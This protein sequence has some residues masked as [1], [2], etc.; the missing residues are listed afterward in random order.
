MLKIAFGRA[1]LLLIVSLLWHQT[2]GVRAAESN[3]RPHLFSLNEDMIRGLDRDNKVDVKDPRSVLYALLSQLQPEATI[4]PSENYYYFTF[5]DHGLAYSGSLRL[6]ADSRDKGLI[7]LNYNEAYSR[8]QRSEGGVETTLG[9]DDGVRVEKLARFLYRVTYRDV[10]VSFKLHELDM[11][12]SSGTKLFPGEVYVGSLFDESG[13]EFDL[14]YSAPRNAFMF[15]LRT[16]GSGNEYLRDIGGGLLLGRR[17]GFVYYNDTMFNRLILVAVN[18]DMLREN[19]AY[20]G[21]FD[22]LPENYFDELKFLDYVYKVYP[23]L[24]GELQPH[25]TYADG[26]IF[27]LIAYVE[28]HTLSDLDFLRRCNAKSP[29]RDRFYDC[30]LPRR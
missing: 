6:P 1:V 7:E 2:Y 26:T 20:D 23:H 4:F 19:S 25:G 18:S 15:L 8:W 16:A 27:A 13:I 3:P 30:I 28:Y 14:V 29:R 11:T 10:S 24:K 12:L 9:P 22:Q 5:Y 17:T 21:P